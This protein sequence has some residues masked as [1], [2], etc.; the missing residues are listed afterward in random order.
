MSDEKDEWVVC[1]GGFFVRPGGIGYTINILEAGVW[2]FDEAKNFIT[3]NQCIAR[4]PDFIKEPEATP[5]ERPKDLR[6][7]FAMAALSG[8]LAGGATYGGRTDDRRATAGDAYA[9]ATAM[10]EARE[11]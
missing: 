9:F 3:G 2:P 1:S 5:T 10:M 6:D 11:K 8:L 7:E 4:R